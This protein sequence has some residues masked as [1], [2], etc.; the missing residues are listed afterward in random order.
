MKSIRDA[1]P[2][3]SG[4]D[5][6]LAQQQKANPRNYATVAL[7][8]LSVT[9]PFRSRIIQFVIINPYF[10]Y[11]ILCIILLNCLGL[12]M[13]NEVEFV[14]SNGKVIDQLFLIIYTIEMVLKIIAMGFTM[15]QHSYLRDPANMVSL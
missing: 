15:R 7:C 2:V 9:N 14:T 5:E 4:I 8:C 3:Q 6:A 13:D 1:F 10:D 11:F 12:A